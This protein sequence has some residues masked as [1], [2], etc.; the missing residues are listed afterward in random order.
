MKEK[1]SREIA[2]RREKKVK[3][4]NPQR[5]TFFLPKMSAILPVGTW[6]AALAKI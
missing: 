2:Q 4:I 1:E 3:R 5:K 6:K